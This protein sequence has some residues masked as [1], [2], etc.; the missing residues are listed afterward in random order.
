M[1]QGYFCSY[2]GE[3]IKM[4]EKKAL[5]CWEEMMRRGA[6]AYNAY[7]FDAARIYLGSAL[8]IGILHTKCVDNS[9]FGSLHVCKP[10]AFLVELALAG[11]NLHLGRRVL[12][13]ITTLLQ[14]PHGLSQKT[15]LDFVAKQYK[16]L[17][18]EEKV[19]EGA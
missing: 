11:A 8:D 15:M 7:R 14:G 3:Q 16:R 1:K 17:D 18:N 10:S 13:Q 9:T 5:R 4:S 19:W 12:E 6:I 2:H